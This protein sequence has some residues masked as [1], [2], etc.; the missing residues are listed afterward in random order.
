MRIVVEEIVVVVVEPIW[1]NHSVL[2]RM[3]GG[4]CGRDSGSKVV[5]G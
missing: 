3:V 5:V 2:V 1:D 4:C